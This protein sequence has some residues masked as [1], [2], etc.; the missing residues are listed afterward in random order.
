MTPELTYEQIQRAI[1][2]VQSK[3]SVK[4]KKSKIANN[5]IIIFHTEHCNG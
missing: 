2:Q 4:I 3:V 5:K 1:K